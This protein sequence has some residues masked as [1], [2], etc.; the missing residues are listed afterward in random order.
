MNWIPAWALFCWWTS[1][2]LHFMI[3]PLMNWSTK[4]IEWSGRLSEPQSVLI[5][6]KVHYYRIKKF[7]FNSN[8]IFINWKH[9]SWMRF[10]SNIISVLDM[11]TDLMHLLRYSIF[12]ISQV[13]ESKLKIFFNDINFVSTRGLSEGGTSQTAVN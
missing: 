6:D 13:I 9:S 12:F 3:V 10:T 2:D 7:D 8:F 5:F 4:W 11:N 1:S